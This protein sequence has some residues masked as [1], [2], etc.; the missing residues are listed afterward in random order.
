MQHRPFLLF[1][2]S[3]PT[4]GGRQK[5]PHHAILLVFFAGD[6]D[7]D[8]DD[9]LFHAGV[10]LEMLLLSPPLLHTNTP[11]FQ[12]ATTALSDILCKGECF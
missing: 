10:Y 2:V 5:P 11:H 3:P 1:F 7:D 8:D 9:E 12:Q 4:L 6:D